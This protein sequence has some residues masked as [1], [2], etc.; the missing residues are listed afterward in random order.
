MVPLLLHPTWK[1]IPLWLLSVATLG[2]V[3]SVVFQLAHCVGR[4]SF[5]EAGA[6]GQMPA[7]WAEHQVATT[8]DF[9]PSSRLLG[10]YL[11]GLN[12]QIE[13]HL[14]PRICHVHYAALSAIVRQACREH[15]VVYSAEPTLWSAL[16][17]NLRWLREMGR[18]GALTAGAV[19]QVS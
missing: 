19:L 1:L 7:G 3:T 15:G 6:D 18:G 13:H 5:P 4:A 12:F 16:A 2:V 9:A 8:V 10:W 11:G 14:F 17:S